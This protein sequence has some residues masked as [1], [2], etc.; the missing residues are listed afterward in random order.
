VMSRCAKLWS[1]C[2]LRVW[3]G[4]GYH[5]LVLIG[6]VPAQAFRAPGHSR[7]RERIPITDKTETDTSFYFFDRYEFLQHSVNEQLHL[8]SALRPIHNPI[9]R[10][11]SAAP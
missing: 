3:R 4:A 2:P 10:G 7:R 6:L 9:A 8:R 11:A 1:L 5:Y